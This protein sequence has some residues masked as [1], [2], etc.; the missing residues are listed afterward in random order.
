MAKRYKMRLVLK[1]RF[2]EFFQEK[3]QKE[4]HRSLMMKMMALEVSLLLLLM[5]LLLID[6]YQLTNQPMDQSQVSDPLLVLQPFSGEDASRQESQSPQEYSH[7]EEHCVRAGV[8]LPL[9][10]LIALTVW[11]WS[12]FWSWL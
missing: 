4:Q 8:T 9:V 3:V 11:L 12:C 1:Q 6:L 2:S 5:L 7:A 10:G